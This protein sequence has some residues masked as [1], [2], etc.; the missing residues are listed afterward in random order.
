MLENEEKNDFEPEEER[1]YRAAILSI[2][3]GD[4]NDELLRELL[5]D[6]HDNDIASV[7]DDLESEERERLLRVLGSDAMS[8]IL[9][10]TDDAAEYIA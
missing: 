8:D 6:Y 4:S 5:E 3:R 9:P 10:F 7:L 2:I 1:D